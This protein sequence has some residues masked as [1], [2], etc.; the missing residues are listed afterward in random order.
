MCEN[1]GLE[2]DIRFNSK[3][4]AVIS[5][6]N[7]LLKDFRFPSFDVKCECVKELRRCHL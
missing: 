4:S 5:F 2:H 3:K 1:C 6:R 7:Y